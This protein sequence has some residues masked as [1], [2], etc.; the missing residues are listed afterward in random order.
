MIQNAIHPTF[1]DSAVIEGV[2]KCDVCLP[3]QPGH[4]TKAAGE[5]KES[6]M[7]HPLG[8][9]PV[10][11]CALPRS[12]C[13]LCIKDTE[14]SPLIDIKMYLLFQWLMPVLSLRK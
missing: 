11:T 13:H 3:P 12:A 14:A 7:A 10:R 8:P 4:G 2:R 1:G 5:Q 6:L 9:G